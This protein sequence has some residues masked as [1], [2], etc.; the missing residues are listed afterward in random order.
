MDEEKRRRMEMDFFQGNTG[1]ATDAALELL[2]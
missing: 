1:P 2:S